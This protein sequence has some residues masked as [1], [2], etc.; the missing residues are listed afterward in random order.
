MDVLLG[1]GFGYDFEGGCTALISFHLPSARSS[2][3][4]R[5]TADGGDGVQLR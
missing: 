1:S 3:S 2:F 5:H 4:E